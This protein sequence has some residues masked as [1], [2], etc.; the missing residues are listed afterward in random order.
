MK[1]S[2]YVCQQAAEK[3]FKGFISAY[4]KDPEKIHDLKTLV[5]RCRDFDRSFSELNDAAVYLNRFYTETRY[6]DD[7]H[8]FSPGEAQQ[9][10][11]AA[12]RI[13]EFVLK[14]IKA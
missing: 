8:A 11:A 7:Y 12:L 9:A 10:L 14:K 4:G 3:Y 2:K 1:V 13:K 6:A 5:I